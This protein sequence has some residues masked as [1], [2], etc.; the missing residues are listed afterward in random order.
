MRITSSTLPFL[1]LALSS[2]AC[3]TEVAEEE[4]ESVE[5]A[6]SAPKPSTGPVT[7]WGKSGGAPVVRYAA[8]GAPR[9]LFSVVTDRIN[10][11]DW[12]PRLRFAELRDGKFVVETVPDKAARAWDLGADANGRPQALVYSDGRMYSALTIWQRDDAG[13]WSPTSGIDSGGYIPGTSEGYTRAGIAPSIA[14]GRDGV[15][16]VSYARERWVTADRRSVDQVVYA[17]REGNGWR[18]EVVAE[19][20]YPEGAV[21]RTSVLIGADNLPH[22]VYGGPGRDAH[23]VRGAGGWSNEALRPSGSMHVALNRS[24][25]LVSLGCEATGALTLMTYQVGKAPVTDTFSLG[26]GPV[27]DCTVTLDYDTSGRPHVAVARPFSLE[28][29]LKESGKWKTYTV[30]SVGA[31]E[32]PALAIRSRGGF[33][34]GIAQPATNQLHF[35]TLAF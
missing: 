22:V 26:S 17:T 11:W 19:W 4:S 21:T 28:Y 9:L 32:S 1:V 18:H 30:S 12:E 35:T 29:A 25:R 20:P 5:A 8:S 3:A 23:A 24:S 7:P 14:Y 33:Q 15:V 6:L 16:H 10:A 31:H 34:V 2:V 13:I 27:T